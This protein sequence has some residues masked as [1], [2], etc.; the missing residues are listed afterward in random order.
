MSSHHT[1]H[2]Y[3]DRPHRMRPEERK[4]AREREQ[5]GQ[6]DSNKGHPKTG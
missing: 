3:C 5:C 1:K 2:A 4:A 6:G